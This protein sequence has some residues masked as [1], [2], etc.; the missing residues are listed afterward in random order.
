MADES[1]V[2]DTL[3]GVVS[4]L[5]Y[6]NGTGQA[7]APGMPCRVYRGWPSAANLDADLA[8]SISNIS[9]FARNGVEQ[10]VTRYPREWETLV[11]PAHT[12]T[13]T[14]SGA[15]CT[16]GGTISTPQN[17]AV[18]APGGRT[19]VYAVQ[20][21]D[22][23]SGLASAL[24]ALLSAKGVACSASGPTITAPGGF[25]FARVGGVGTAI[26]ELRRQNKS[27]QITLWCS[28]PANRD[29]VAGVIDPG[30]ALLNFI[31]LPDGSSGLVRYE[32]TTTD[33]A[34]E[35]ELLWRRDLFYWVEYPTTQTIAATE[36][37]DVVTNIAGSQVP[38]AAP[39]VATNS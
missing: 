30:L 14:V 3:V 34:P 33:D 39:P 12:I 32:R 9:I 26:R 35:K 27:V 28:S 23:L 25:T 1:Q 7:S 13:A 19:V 18:Q 2:L 20:P 5:V 11:P 37:I 29:A 22:T 38:H 6:P 17:V 8:A 4:G 31:S 36:I 16:F 24:Q 15:T 10:V 21:A